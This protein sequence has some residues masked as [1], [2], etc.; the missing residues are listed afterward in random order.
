MKKHKTVQMHK[1]FS[2][3]NDFGAPSSNYA[4]WSGKNPTPNNQIQIH[5]SVQSEIKA[6]FKQN[7]WT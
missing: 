7:P 6:A 5:V 3:L 4:S 1:L 2:F